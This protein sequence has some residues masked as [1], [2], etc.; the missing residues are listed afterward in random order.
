MKT[1]LDGPRAPSRRSTPRKSTARAS[2]SRHSPAATPRRSTRR[3]TAPP[4][5][6]ARGCAVFV[7]PAC[8][9]RARRQ[10]AAIDAS[11]VF[12]A[13]CSRRA[14]SADARLLRGR[15]HAH[16]PARFVADT[17]LERRESRRR[18]RGEVDADSFGAASTRRTKKGRI[19]RAGGYAGRIGMKAANDDPLHLHAL[20][21][22]VVRSAQGAL[23]TALLLAFEGRAVKRASHALSL[24]RSATAAP[25]RSGRCPAR[26]RTSYPC[27]S[28]FSG[29]PDRNLPA[30]SRVSDLDTLPFSVV[31]PG[32]DQSSRGDRGGVGYGGGASS[33]E[34]DSAEPAL[35]ERPKGNA[36]RT[37]ATREL[38]EVLPERGHK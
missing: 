5:A 36:A 38:T 4:A 30:S 12:R 7:Q 37:A 13:R 18:V 8:G 22:A 17:A 25:A 16:G 35:A 2:A 28:A 20:P 6:A 9:G 23:R 1:E 3:K 21:L 26:K 11:R 33:E 19:E 31:N 14:S 24:A 32:S 15:A 29:A 10:A 34:D 27:S